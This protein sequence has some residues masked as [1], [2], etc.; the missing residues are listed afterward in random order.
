MCMLDT[1][2]GFHEMKKFD[3]SRTAQ[4]S[5]EIARHLDRLIEMTY[6]AAPLRQPRPNRK[7]L[8]CLR[9]IPSTPSDECEHL[10]EKAIRMQW[11]KSRTPAE[12]FLPGVCEHIQAEQVP[13]KE[14][15][16]DEGWSEIDLVGVSPQFLPVVL[17]LKIAHMKKDEEAN[18]ES[19]LRMLVEGLAYAI[20]VKRAWNE[21]HFRTAWQEVVDPRATM[22]KHLAEV[23]IVGI[24]PNEYWDRRMG[25][26]GRLGILSS[27]DWHALG[28]FVED[29]AQKGFPVHFVQYQKGE[30]GEDGLPRI[31]H[32]VDISEKVASLKHEPKQSR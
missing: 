21:G 32:I 6:A 28:K 17:E 27:Q 13:L 12:G 29:L 2:R 18:D 24:A 1:S 11:D 3:F 15:D 26:A 9:R 23:P 19:P 20:G 31:D 4:D 8:Y 25:K 22:P 5:Q 16:S 30:L 7:D 14:Y 10:Y